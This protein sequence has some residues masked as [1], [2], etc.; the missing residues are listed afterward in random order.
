MGTK[1]PLSDA[2]MET[3][4]SAIRQAKAVAATKLIQQRSHEND[5]DKLTLDEINAEI[6]LARRE[7]KQ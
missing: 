5:T 3:T 1:T 2:T 6:A 7:R 4:L